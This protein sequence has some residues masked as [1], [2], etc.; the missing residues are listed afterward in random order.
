M[1]CFTRVS[2]HEKTDDAFI[3]LECLKTPVKHEAQ[4]FEMASQSAPN[5]KQKKGKEIKEQ[6]KA[7]IT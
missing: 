6:K 3:V 5:C 1:E 7:K 2:K 4:V